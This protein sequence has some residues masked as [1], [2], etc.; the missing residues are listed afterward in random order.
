MLLQESGYAQ[1]VLKGVLSL[2]LLEDS[3]PL[4]IGFA[5]LVGIWEDHY[6]VVNQGREE[7]RLEGLEA[8]AGEP[9]EIGEFL[10]ENDRRFLALDNTNRGRIFD[11]G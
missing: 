5:G 6:F 3:E 4:L 11:H 7:F 2:R 8:T 10:T 9:H 1:R